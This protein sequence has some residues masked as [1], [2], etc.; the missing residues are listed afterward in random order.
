M[1]EVT[2]AKTMPLDALPVAEF[3]FPGPLRDRLV[4]LILAGVKTSTS[5]L[6]AE[7]APGEN[8]R[9]DIGRL[10][11]VIDSSGNIV[12][13]IR[14][15]DIQVVRLADVSDAHAIAEGEGFRN[16][17]EWRVAHERFWSSAPLIDLIGR[18]DIT[19]DTQVVC[20]TFTVEPQ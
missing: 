19:D 4:A 2:D 14:I 11:A 8:P 9:T 5:C 10:E 3:A 13:V 1:T 15:L 17:H 6:L 16:A 7:Y 20:S 12:C 18:V